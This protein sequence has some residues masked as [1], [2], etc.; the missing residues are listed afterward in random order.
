MDSNNSDFHIADLP[1]YLRWHQ[2]SRLSHQ[3]APKKVCI[4]GSGNWGSAIARLVG[5]N[6]ERLPE[7]FQKDVN[8][9]VFEEEVNGRK[10]TEIINTDHE[11]V[12]YLPGRTLPKN[13]IAIPDIV[14]AAA[15]A[16]FLIFVLPHQFIKRACAPLVGK[17]K[18]EA[19]GLSLV[20]VNE[21]ITNQKIRGE[22]SGIRHPTR[23]GYQANQ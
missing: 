23:R 19:T 1:S 12:K 4:V 2:F 7:R 22:I 16:D 10:L 18:K 3:M 20:K 8:M 13:V 17:L 15:E 11:N 6:A 14:E 21:I 9:W 5:F